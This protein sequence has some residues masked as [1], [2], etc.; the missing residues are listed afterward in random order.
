[1]NQNSSI[2]YPLPS[3]VD[4]DGDKVA[5]FVFNFKQTVLF[6]RILANGTLLVSP[7]GSI[8]PGAYNIDI[9]IKD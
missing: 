8:R 7:S 5:P 2:A 3:V 6:T 1:V 9:T 4:P